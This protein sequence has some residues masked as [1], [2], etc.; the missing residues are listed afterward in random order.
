[1]IIKEIFWGFDS[2]P[3]NSPALW[4]IIYEPSVFYCRKI[5]QKI[6]LSVVEVQQLNKVIKWLKGEKKTNCRIYNL[7]RGILKWNVRTPV[8]WK[9]AYFENFIRFYTWDSCYRNIPIIKEIFGAPTESLR[10][11]LYCE[12]ALYQ[13]P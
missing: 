8:N 1:M 5:W 12:S 9:I 4:R 7:M 10:V 3:S 13:N 6:N 11:F 2:K